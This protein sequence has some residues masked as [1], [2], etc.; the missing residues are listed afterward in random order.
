M[1]RRVA[2]MLRS[3][4]Q[5]PHDDTKPLSTSRAEVERSR[6]SSGIHLDR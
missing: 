1:E 5:L 3:Q 6:S 2:S 4:R